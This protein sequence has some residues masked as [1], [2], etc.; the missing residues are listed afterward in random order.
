MSVNRA[1]SNPE[2]I[3]IDVSFDDPIVP[4][5][6][7]VDLIDEP[8]ENQDD[9][10]DQ[11]NPNEQ[12]PLVDTTES[13]QEQK[14]NKTEI[15]L[16][17]TE[18]EEG[19]EDNLY[20]KIINQGFDTGLFDPDNLYEGFDYD[21]EPSEEVLQKFIE[22][23]IKLK[24]EKA[25]EEFF[26]EISPL[27]QRILQYDLNSKGQGL[28][29]F[30]KI[31]NEEHSI[32]SLDPTNEYDQEKIVR[33]WYNDEDFSASEIDE[34]IEDLKTAGLLNKEASRLKPKLDAKAE[35]IAKQEEESQKMLAQIENQRKQGFYQKVET[36]I[37]TGK[38]DGIPVGKEDA[39]A[40]L[41][42]L[43]AEDVRIKLPEGREVKMNAFEAEIF[44]HKY[45]NKGDVKL[46]LKAALLLTN[47]DKFYKH[48][49]QQVKTEQ[50]NEFVKAQKYN[51]TKSQAK[52]ETKKEVKNIPWNRPK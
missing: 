27:A 23:N 21:T 1:F 47:P 16:E 40:V 34:K 14:T 12:A 37:K 6:P 45:S 33:L 38:V 2:P 49:A 7:G 32:K 48:F 15:T 31:V 39:Q 20:L 17:E 36:E 28:D 9:Q 8:E 35:A 51:I 3:T 5:T 26:G 46:L 18:E 11:N 29:S 30:I 52:P 24:E 19:Y 43:F 10:N 42:L 22:H 44:K 13:E 25:I 41:N 4:T 50:V